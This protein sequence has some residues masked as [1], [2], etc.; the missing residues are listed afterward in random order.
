MTQPKNHTIEDVVLQHY[1]D[2]YR[3]CYFRLHDRSTAQDLTQE[4]FCRFFQRAQKYSRDNSIRQLLF[5]IAR[6]LCI[7]HYRKH[8]HEQEE[9][10]PEQALIQEGMRTVEKMTY[11][12]R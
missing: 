10:S 9:L 6:N 7:D 1:A 5:V 3:Y 2:I 11:I 4:V 12:R 8:T